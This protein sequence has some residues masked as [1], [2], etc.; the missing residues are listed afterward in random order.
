MDNL[1]PTYSPNSNERVFIYKVVIPSQPPN[2][3][4]GSLYR[5]SNFSFRVTYSQ[6]SQIMQRIARLGG[7]IVSIEPFSANNA[8]KIDKTS[9]W[10][11][12]ISTAQPKC[13]YYFGPFDSADEAQSHK[14][15]YVEDLQAEGAIGIS[16][17]IKQC[18][19]QL[20]TQE[21]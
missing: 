12:E 17:D 13:L 5:R 18:Y 20:L 1:D 3:N 6:M 2:S 4:T 14:P 10:W 21:E 16:I 19:P 8:D 9:P 15:G 7:K 11:V